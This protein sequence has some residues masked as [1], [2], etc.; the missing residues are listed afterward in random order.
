[1][2]A[3]QTYIARRNEL[4][5]RMPKGGIVVLIGNGE[6]PRNYFDN[7]YGFRQDST[8]LY[9]FGLQNAN[10]VGV[11]DLDNEVDTLFGDDYTVDDIIWMGPQPSIKEL[12]ES[13]GVGQSAPFAAARDCVQAAVRAGRK[14]HYLVPYRGE[15]VLLM[16]KLTGI[17]TSEH[18]NH[19]STDLAINVAAMRE[20]KSA[21]EIEEMERAFQIGYAMHTTAMRLTKEGVSE[22]VIAGAMEGVTHQMGDGV[23]FH[24]IVS[25]HGETL[26]NHSH[27]GICENG[28]LLLVD[29]G[30]ET[31]NNYCSDHTRTFPVSGKFTP[32]QRDIYNVVLHA[33]DEV[34][35]IAKPGK[36]TDLH[37]ASYKALAEGLIGLGLM[38]G[39]AEE[40]VAAGAVRLFMPH[41]L[42]HGLGMDVH[43]CEAMG[44]R[45]MADYGAM[46]A[47]ADEIDTCII[48]DRWL[49]RPGTVLTDEPG[50][51]FIPAYIEQ[52]K[53]ERKCEEFINYSKLEALYNFGGIRI[54]DD[55]LIT[56]SGNIML[57][58]DKHIPVTVD[59]IEAFMA[60]N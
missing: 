34:L 25:Q 46:L 16:S 31:V 8:F 4:R 45:G 18:Y 40:A 43:D 33:H 19:Y 32:L 1:M 24:S 47:R 7:A 49:L 55:L 57:G 22:R 12:A 13:V 59:E 38:K 29:A 58:G 17:K 9:Y 20:V 36:Y 42:G 48:R 21:E 39:N 2:F 23:S 35:R 5:R 50:I 60:E 53:A 27:D 41:G 14:V 52:W 44:E 51:Y 56:E 11:I 28:R 37:N 26:H 6:A 10:L 54:E 30:G 15:G 3:K